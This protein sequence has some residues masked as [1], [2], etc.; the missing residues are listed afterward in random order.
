MYVCEVHD[1]LLPSSTNDSPGAYPLPDLGASDHFQVHHVWTVQQDSLSQEGAIRDSP[2]GHL[3]VDEQ[4]R[5][6]Q[7]ALSATIV[8]ATNTTAINT[9]SITSLRFFVG[10]SV[11]LLRLIHHAPGPVCGAVLY[12]AAIQCDIHQFDTLEEH[13]VRVST[14]AVAGHHIERL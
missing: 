13:L 3:P 2:G 10:E 5:Q 7:D 1:S 14:A 12:R 11:P 6:G 4:R 9:A 8:P